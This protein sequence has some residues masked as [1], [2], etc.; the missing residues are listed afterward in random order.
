MKIYKSL[1]F[2]GPAC[3]VNDKKRNTDRV[4]KQKVQMKKEERKGEENLHINFAFIIIYIGND[5]K[6]RLN[7]K[8]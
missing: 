7:K 8:N 2:C 4:S 5:A 3:R 6:M 1:R